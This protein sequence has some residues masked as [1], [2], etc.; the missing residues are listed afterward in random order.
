MHR[1]LLTGG[2]ALV[3]DAYAHLIEA[4]AA[5]TVQAQIPALDQALDQLLFLR[6][7]ILVIDT[8]ALAPSPRTTTLL[9]LRQAAARTRLALIGDIPVEDVDSL[10]RV[11]VTGILS[12]HVEVDHFVMAL[13]VVGRG[14]LIV[15][16]PTDRTSTPANPPDPMLDQLSA[17]ELQILALVATQHSNNA[18]AHLLG[19]SPLTIK[20]H[21]NRILRKL[22]ASTRAH[23][24]AIAYESGLVTPG[25]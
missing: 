23:L 25:L 5:L 19:I 3:R 18:L 15:S 2:H 24:V 12:P 14:G 8:L 6:P 20:T 11:G 16:S 10:L 1:V 21:V 9:S 13:D 7:D 22:G 4:S 17:R